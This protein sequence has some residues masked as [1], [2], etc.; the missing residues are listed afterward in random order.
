MWNLIKLDTRNGQKW[1]IQYHL[2]SE[3]RVVEVLNAEALVAKED[4]MEDR[5]ALYSTQSLYSFILLD[6]LSGKTWQV[7][8]STDP[9]ER[10]FVPIE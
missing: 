3:N 10:L 4:E 1:Q 9:K 2:E 8:W 7:Q 5:F 6:Q